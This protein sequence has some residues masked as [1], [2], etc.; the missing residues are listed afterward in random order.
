MTKKIYL[1]IKKRNC[2][3]ILGQVAFPYISSKF[4]LV[5]VVSVSSYYISNLDNTTTTNIH[6]RHL[7]TTQQQQ[8]I[9]LKGTK[10]KDVC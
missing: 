6:K 5:V 2:S 7:A 1:H 4:E 9:E 10:Y 8:Q 3:Y